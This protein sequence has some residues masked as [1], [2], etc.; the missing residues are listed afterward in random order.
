LDFCCLALPAGKSYLG[1]CEGPLFR[2]LETSPMTGPCRP[3]PYFQHTKEAARTWAGT[4][5]QYTNIRRQG[6]RYSVPP[7]DPMSE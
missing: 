4:L 6:M 3:H 5:Q 2:V 7:V 1:N